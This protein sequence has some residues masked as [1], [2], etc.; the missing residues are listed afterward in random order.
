MATATRVKSKLRNDELKDAYQGWLKDLYDEKPERVLKKRGT[1]RRSRQAQ[2]MLHVQQPTAA[3]ALKDVALNKGKLPVISLRHTPEDKQNL[4]DSQR[5][6]HQTLVAEANYSAFQYA[7]HPSWRPGLAFFQQF[8]RQLL[9]KSTTEAG[10]EGVVSL[11]VGSFPV[12]VAPILLR[13]PLYRQGGKQLSVALF[14][15]LEQNQQ[16]IETGMGMTSFVLHCRV[17]LQATTWREHRNFLLDTVSNASAEICAVRKCAENFESR[18]NELQLLKSRQDLEKTMDE[19]WVDDY[20]TDLLAIQKY[21]PFKGATNTFSS[22]PSIERKA[23]IARCASRKR[24]K[25]SS[26]V[27]IISGGDYSDSSSTTITS[28]SSTDCQIVKCTID[29]AWLEPRLL[30]SMCTGP[31][32]KALRIRFSELVVDLLQDTSGA[33]WLLQVKAFTLAS[34]RPVSAASVSTSLSNQS[35]SSLSRTKSAPTCFDV[36]IATSQWKKWRCAGR[37][38]VTKGKNPSAKQQLGDD[39]KEPRGYLT[40]KMMRSCEFYDDFV[41]RQDMSLAGGFTDFHSAL[42]FHLQHRLSKRDRS[43]LYEPQ[44][45]CSTC[46]KKYHLLRQQWIETVDPPKSSTESNIGG[47]RKKNVYVKTS[48]EGHSAPHKLPALYALPAPLKTSSSAPVIAS[49]SHSN[50]VNTAS[51]QP[52]YLDDMAAMEKML[53]EHEPSS[54]LSATK[55]EP[56]SSENQKRTVLNPLITKPGSD[57]IFPKWDGATR[58]EEMWQNLTFKPLD[59]QLMGKK[60]G[61]NSI[62][63]KQELAK[64]VEN[65]SQT[66]HNEDY[67]R[68]EKNVVHKIHVQHCRQV[69]EDEMYR[70][71]LVNNAYNALHSGKAT[72]CFVV[73]P[74]SNPERKRTDGDDQVAEMALRSLYIDVKQSIADDSSQTSLSSWPLRPTVYRE[75]SGCISVKLGPR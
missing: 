49:S 28:S 69:F 24:E 42:G 25:K 27:W 57:N 18:N 59:N 46:V 63:L 5:R 23:W 54:L 45:L 73:P 66:K 2:R 51:N 68:E 40:K 70:E 44:P 62:S 48:S 35:P 64:A 36:G 22:T 60:Q 33:W 26:T 61:Y 4:Q 11:E 9:P 16:M 14:Y 31:L 41:R 32:E 29:Q 53:A 52:N 47:H 13:V 39:E 71:D 50:S 43:Q 21:I 1:K 15:C 34:L 20:D 65:N 7:P 37:F 6:R 72:V 67:Q 30:A 55:T 74:P 56:P 75:A 38:C 19:L 10:N 8:V 12:Q 17:Y 3:S 58:I